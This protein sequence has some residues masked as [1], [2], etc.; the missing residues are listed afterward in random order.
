MQLH[1]P[2]PAELYHRYVEFKPFVKRMFT[3][4]GVRGFFLHK[5]LSHQHDQIYRFDKKT[6]SGY[7]PVDPG[8]ESSLKFLELVDFDRGG[9][10]FTYVITLDSLWRFTET[11]KEFGIDMLS[12][13]TMHSDV[14]VYIAF[15]GEFFVRRVKN[16]DQKPPE[17]GGHNETHPPEPVPGGPPEG[18][19]P[20]DPSLYELIID[21]DSGTYRPNADLLPKLKEF[22]EF[23]LP[24]IKIVTLDCNTDAKL[25][26]KLKKEQKESKKEEGDTVMYK[27]AAQ[28]SS[29]SSS[30]ESDLDD[31]I[32]GEQEDP[33]LLKTMKH[34]AAARR[35]MKKKHWKSLAKGRGGEGEGDQQ[36]SASQPKVTTKEGEAL[37]TNGVH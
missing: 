6:E 34:D 29:I 2:V 4:S 24:G 37:K 11:G 12:K 1:G 14:S 21:N 33:G 18:D 30:D 10:I 7:L 35:S 8:K 15:S 25:Q 20:K 17:L 31:M 13:H 32:N 23:N 36:A 9:R 3:H 28:G 22:L 16:R 19:S 5:A 26:Q 27:Q